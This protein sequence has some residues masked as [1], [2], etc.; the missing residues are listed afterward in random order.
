MTRASVER[1][2]LL[3]FRTNTEAS[4]QILSILNLTAKSIP[5]KVTITGPL[6]KLQLIAASPSD[7]Q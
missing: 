1:A 4:L 3:G 6:E 5:I 2:S 7:F